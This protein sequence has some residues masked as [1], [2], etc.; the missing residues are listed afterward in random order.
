MT[1]GQASRI[2]I[3]SRHPSLYNTLSNV[4]ACL[5]GPLILLCFFHMAN[6][7]RLYCSYSTRIMSNF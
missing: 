1:M 6:T 5:C 3:S 7:A 2:G 4:I